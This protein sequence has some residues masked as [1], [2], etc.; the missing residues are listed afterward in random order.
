MDPVR[1]REPSACLHLSM[2]MRG[3]W[4][5]ATSS[6]YDSAALSAGRSC[7]TQGKRCEKCV[8]CLLVGPAGQE[9]SVGINVCDGR[10]VLF[11]KGQGGASI[12][13]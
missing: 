3:S 1:P 7:R 2:G 10:A 4:S 12:G 5:Q 9:G 13:V 8:I 6:T 11:N